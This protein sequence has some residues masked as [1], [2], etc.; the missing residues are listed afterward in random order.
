MN[1]LTNRHP[2]PPCLTQIRNHAHN[3]FPFLQLFENKSS[4]ASREKMTPV[5]HKE[6]CPKTIRN[7]EDN[8]SLQFLHGDQ[9][10]SHP[11]CSNLAGDRPFPGSKDFE[12]NKNP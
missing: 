4:A 6:H 12:R 5:V 1:Y 9:S 3:L 11:R 10:R 8:T 2:S 7:Q